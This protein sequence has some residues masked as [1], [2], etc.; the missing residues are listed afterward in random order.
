MVDP[1]NSVFFEYHRTGDKALT[2]DAAS[3]VEGIGRPRVEPSFVPA[4]IDRMIRVSTVKSFA[5]MR[6]LAS[7]TGKR[8]GGSTGTDFY[9]ALQ[10]GCEMLATGE[11]GSIVF[12]ACDAGDRYQ[13][14]YYDDQWLSDQGHDIEP[15]MQA[16]RMVC[17]TGVW[18][19]L[20]TRPTEAVAS[21]AQGGS[22]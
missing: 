12:L 5:A 22:A 8:Y 17:N 11:T 13:D 4:V 9:G 1:D 6:L 21:A 16:L 18:S 15:H 20:A 19:P 3:G 14:T 7:L 10:L 2:H